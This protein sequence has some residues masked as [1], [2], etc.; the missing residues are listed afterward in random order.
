MVRFIIGG[1][2]L[3][4]ITSFLEFDE[5]NALLGS[6]HERCSNKKNIVLSMDSMCARCAAIEKVISSQMKPIKSI[7]STLSLKD[8]I[9]CEFDKWKPVSL[10]IS[11][12]Q[13]AYDLLDILV[14]QGVIVF[15]KEYP[16]S[17]FLRNNVTYT[18]TST[19]DLFDFLAR[20]VMKPKLLFDNKVFSANWNDDLSHNENNEIEE[21]RHEQVQS[22]IYLPLFTGCKRNGCDGFH[23][24]RI[25]PSVDVSNEEI[26]DDESEKS[27]EEKSDEEKSDEEKSEEESYLAEQCYESGSDD[28]KSY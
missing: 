26:K 3:S 21:N 6:A 5:W 7:N 18:Y 28:L 13:T 17:V 10:Y 14:Q 2:L 23:Y 1:S 12:G 27:D 4:M 9:A 20:S 16:D 24:S 15:K 8:N 11:F 25:C 22:M 19:W